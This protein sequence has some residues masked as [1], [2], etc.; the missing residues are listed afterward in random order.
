[1]TTWIN[2]LW[3]Q[4]GDLVAAEDIQTGHR[5]EPQNRFDDTVANP[6]MQRRIRDDV[7][8]DIDA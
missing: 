5:I 7:I 3:Y 4:G 1:M 6:V 8:E 2:P